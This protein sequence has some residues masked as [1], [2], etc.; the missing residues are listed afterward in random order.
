M[1]YVEQPLRIFALNANIA[2]ILFFS[3]LYDDENHKTIIFVCL[4]YQDRQTLKTGNNNFKIIT[5]YDYHFTL[6]KHFY[7]ELSRYRTFSIFSLKV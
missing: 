7:N 1:L 4:R 5:C 2:F 3:H 6:N